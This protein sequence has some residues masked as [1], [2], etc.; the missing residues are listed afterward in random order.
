MTGTSAMS[1]GTWSLS[2]KER[3][4]WAA[5]AARS[6]AMLPPRLPRSKRSMLAHSQTL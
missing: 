2:S 4:A 5:T 3:I 1:R 6:A